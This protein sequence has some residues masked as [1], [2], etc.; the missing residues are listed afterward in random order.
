MVGKVGGH[1]PLA[2]VSGGY[3]FNFGRDGGLRTFVLQLKNT[4]AKFGGSGGG[5]SGRRTFV[6]FSSTTANTNATQLK[7]GAAVVLAVVCSHL[8]PR[9]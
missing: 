5:S 4:T 8:A 9:N 6:E 3:L 7:I 1:L 2:V